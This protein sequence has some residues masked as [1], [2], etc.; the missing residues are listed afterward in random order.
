MCVDTPIHPSIH[1]CSQP[2]VRVSSQK[3]T[4]SEHPSIHRSS[5]KPPVDATV[6]KLVLGDVE[7]KDKRPHHFFSVG[8][9]IQFSASNPAA[10]DLAK[11]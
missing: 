9:Y 11:S 1:P 5:L 2:S 4:P 8:S 3:I 6:Y 10:A 7:L